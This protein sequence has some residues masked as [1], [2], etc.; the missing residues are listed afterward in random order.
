MVTWEIL[1]T[2]RCSGQLIHEIVPGKTQPYV[3]EDAEHSHTQHT[4]PLM[5]AMSACHLL[6]RQ[7]GSRSGSC[8]C[9]DTSQLEPRSSEVQSGT[10]DTHLPS[11]PGEAEPGKGT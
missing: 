5:S 2:C 4:P 9:V 8:H 7:K 1:I 6:Q 3:G 10:T 11:V